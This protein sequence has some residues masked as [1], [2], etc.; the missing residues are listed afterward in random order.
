[1]RRNENMRE[2]FQNKKSILKQGAGLMLAIATAAAFVTGCGKG[3]K[4]SAS[5]GQENLSEYV[6]TSEYIPL[7]INS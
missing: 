4:A 2:N 6:Y 7:E 3:E 1:M 5:A